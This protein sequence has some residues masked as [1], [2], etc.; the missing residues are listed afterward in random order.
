M[1]ACGLVDSVADFF[2]GLPTRAAAEA[3]KT[4]GLHDTYLFVVTGVGSW[5]VDVNDGRV[6]VS[7]GDA[8]HATCTITTDEQTFLGIAN[9]TQ[10]PATA[11]MFG[12]VKIGGDMGAAMRLKSVF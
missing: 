5:T 12:K 1:L 7:E 9:G 11:V 10:N 3:E 4:R 2:A 6:D 8:G